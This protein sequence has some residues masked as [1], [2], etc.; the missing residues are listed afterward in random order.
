[1]VIGIPE[2]MPEALRHAV[3]MAIIEP[4]KTPARDIYEIFK[5]FFRPTF[6]EATLAHQKLL[7]E[8]SEERREVLRLE[9][10]LKAHPTKFTNGLTQ[11]LEGG[12]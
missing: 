6:S 5:E 2:E 7:V 12:Q 9:A 3:A 11:Y 10:A 4:G 1:M 8:L